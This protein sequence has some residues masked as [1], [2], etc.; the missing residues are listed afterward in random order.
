MRKRKKAREA[1]LR[2]EI[3]LYEVES[4][5]RYLKQLDIE[6]AKKTER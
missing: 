3:L 5:E 6:D 4:I 1:L 2:K